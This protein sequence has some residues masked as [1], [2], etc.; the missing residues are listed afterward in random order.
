MR[1]GHR[2]TEHSANSQPPNVMSTMRVVPL[3]IGKPE[4]VTRIYSLT[5][6]AMNGERVGGRRVWWDATFDVV[7]G[8]LESLTLS[9]SGECPYQYGKQYR[10]EYRLV[11]TEVQE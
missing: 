6:V 1:E 11:V 9:G 3:M 10:M 8:A 4:D 2:G 7:G 5:C